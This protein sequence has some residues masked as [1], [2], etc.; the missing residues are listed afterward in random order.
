MYGEG[1][2]QAIQEFAAENDIDLAGSWAYSDSVS[3]LPM[4]SAVGN[5]VCV[6]P[7]DELLEIAGAE[8]W[9]VM[10]F[11]RLGRRLGIVVAA[12]AAAMVGTGG[13]VASRRVRDR[14]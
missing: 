3:D 5:P 11:E 6:N 7:D 12:L 13:A 4:L 14:T 10:R 8:G 2:V 1:K 9:R